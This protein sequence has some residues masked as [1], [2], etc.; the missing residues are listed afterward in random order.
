MGVCVFVSV[1][2]AARGVKGCYIARMLDRE[3]ERER[4]WGGGGNDRK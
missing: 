3:R 1:C 2:E 4:E